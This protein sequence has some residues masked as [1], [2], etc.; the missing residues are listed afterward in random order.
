MITCTATFFFQ[1]REAQSEMPQ[2]AAALTGGT[3]RPPPRGVY[4]RTEQEVNAVLS[5]EKLLRRFS[6]TRCDAD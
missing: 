2:E 4:H 1:N 6:E 5:Q 3:N